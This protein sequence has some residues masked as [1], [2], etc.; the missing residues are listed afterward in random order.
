MTFYNNLIKHYLLT[1]CDAPE[2]W[3]MNLQ[4]P[5]TPIVEGMIFFHNYLLTF[6]CASQV[7]DTIQGFL[8]ELGMKPRM[9]LEV[10]MFFS[11]YHFIVKPT[12]IM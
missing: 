8:C 11:L 4:D 9:Q 3:Q 12:K 2:A 5:A 6:L 1:F 7:S 10:I